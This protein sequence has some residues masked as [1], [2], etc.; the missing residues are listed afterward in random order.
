MTNPE[1]SANNDESRKSLSF[2]MY[3]DKTCSLR[4]QV[5]PSTV[6]ESRSYLL[7]IWLYSHIVKSPVYQK[8]VSLPFESY[9]S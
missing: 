5:L 1:F 9:L 2:T 8:F 6:W 4:Q 7:E 3:N